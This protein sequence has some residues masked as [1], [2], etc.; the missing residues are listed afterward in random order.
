MV[1][2][3]TEICGLDGGKQTV[4][5]T[6]EEA[7]E[8]IQLFSSIEE[9]LNNTD[10]MEEAVEIFD[11]AIVELDRYGVLPNGMSFKE[12]QQLV[13]GRFKNPITKKVFNEIESR[14]KQPFDNNENLLC[15]IAGSL[16]G[17]TWFLS[18][19]NYLFINAMI[20]GILILGHF[21]YGMD[22]LFIIYIILL[23]ILA[24]TTFM[25][26]IINPICLGRYIYFDESEKPHGMVASFGLNG[27]K[28]WRNNITGLIPHVLDSVGV[29][30]FTGIKLQLSNGKNDMLTLFLGFAPLVRIESSE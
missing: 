16:L 8:V 26:D 5:L 25:I 4:K 3:T 6:Q 10:S 7:E 29:V 15:L 20:L 9:Q 12:A 21:C 19:W 24:A 13:T 28:I 30:G 22:L 1:E 23:P 27:Q 2:F 14:Q 11:E 18:L 17:F